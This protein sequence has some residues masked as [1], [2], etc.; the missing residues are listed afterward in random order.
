LDE[1]EDAPG[2]G[3]GTTARLQKEDSVKLTK[4]KVIQQI[5]TE[6]SI[7]VEAVNGEAAVKM[8]S[9]KAEEDWKTE[10]VTFRSGYQ[11]LP[12]REDADA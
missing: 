2:G 7:E 11:L 8:I 6:Y 10:G 3:V 5:T 9:E 12:V 1:N 4:Y